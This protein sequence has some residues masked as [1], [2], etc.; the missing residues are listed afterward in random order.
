MDMKNRALCFALRNP[1]TGVAKTKLKD[2]VKVVKKMSGRRP[3]LGAVAEAAASFGDEKGVVGRPVGSRKT[4]KEE[5]K[6]V[7]TTFHKMRPPG[8]GVDSRLIHSA[9]PRTLKKKITRRTVV[10]RLAEKGIR[11]EK[12]I[13]KSDPGPA[14][15]RTRL[16]FAKKFEGK[17]AQSWKADLQAVGD[18]KEFTWYPKALQPKFKRLRAPWTYMTKAEKKLPAFVRP[19]RW[20]PKSQYKFVKKQKVFGFTASSGKMLAFL[21][22]SPWSTEKWARLVKTQLAPF[23]KAAFPNRREFQILLDGEKV[24]HGPAAKTAFR[25]H[26]ITVLPSWPKYSPDLNPQEHVWTIA[27]KALRLKEQDDYS[28]DEWKKRLVP[29]VKAYPSP[30]KLIPSMA[31][32]CAQVFARSGAMTDK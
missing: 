17:T 11:P 19:K 15:M 2:I 13:N 22:P 12:K 28:F 23:L 27:E 7:L 32:R 25:E 3:T 20:F 30:E 5:D 16:A 4:T 21:V 1:P 9:L 6:Q 29:A 8:H 26:K 24:L 31:K 14:L 10:H 18:I